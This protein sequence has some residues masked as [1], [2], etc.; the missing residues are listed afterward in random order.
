M[1]E[2]P[3]SSAP[4]PPWTATPIDVRCTL[5]RDRKMSTKAAGSTRPPSPCRPLRRGRHS[6]VGPDGC[7][8]PPHEAGPGLRRPTSPW[9]AVYVGSGPRRLVDSTGPE[10][11]VR[12]CVEPG[13]GQDAGA[14]PEPDAH[15]PVAAC[16]CG[17]RPSSLRRSVDAGPWTAGAAAHPPIPGTRRAPTRCRRGRP[18][19]PRHGRRATCR[20]PAPGR[21]GVAASQERWPS[22]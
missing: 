18:T 8:R 10:G 1:S 14:H 4:P 20:R 5:P 22:G 9:G 15:P 3:L 2:G 17:R 16:S 13:S 21:G 12:A 6:K 19:S 7:I 11:P